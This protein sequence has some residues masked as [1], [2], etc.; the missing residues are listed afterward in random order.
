MHWYLNRQI[1]EGLCRSEEPDNVYQA[2][3]RIKKHCKEFQEL[4]LKTQPPFPEVHSSR[5]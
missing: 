4:K 2:L 5:M 3:Q 1:P